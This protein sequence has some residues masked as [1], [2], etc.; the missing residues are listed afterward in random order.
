M[1]AIMTSSK[2]NQSILMV[3]MIQDHLEIILV[4][5][6]EIIL[7]IDNLEILMEILMEII[8][9][10]SVEIISSPDSLET[11]MLIILTHDSL[12]D[13]YANNFEPRQFGNPHVN[14]E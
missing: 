7:S 4:G 8:L 6:I 2:V 13:P 11:L 12:E 3:M 14:F 9:V 1:A 5:N 10:G